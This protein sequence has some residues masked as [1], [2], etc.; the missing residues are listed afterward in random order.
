M[1]KSRLVNTPPAPNNDNYNN[2]RLQ[3]R[4]LRS[5]SFGKSSLSILNFYYYKL[6]VWDNLFRN[7]RPLERSELKPEKTPWREHFNPALS[8]ENEL[9]ASELAWPPNQAVSFS[10]GAER[11]DGKSSLL[12]TLMPSESFSTEYRLR[13]SADFEAVF[14]NTTIRVSGKYLLLQS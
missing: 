8:N 6:T 4:F 1:Q 10:K 5:P 3:I 14:K 9:M 13:K 12:S 2:N 7:A 11:K